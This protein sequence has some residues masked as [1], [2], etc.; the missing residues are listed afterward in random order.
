MM[1]YSVVVTAPGLSAEDLAV[2]AGAALST[3]QPEEQEL[4]QSSDVTGMTSREAVAVFV[5]TVAANVSSAFI[6]GAVANAL[7]TPDP[8]VEVEE[9]PEE[10]AE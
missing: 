2:Q 9:L 7:A 3:L 8:V 6:V 4:V 10:E 1:R 5:I